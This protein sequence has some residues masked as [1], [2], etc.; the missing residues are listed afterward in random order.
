[1][2]GGTRADDTPVHQALREALV[3]CLANA[4]YYGRQGLVIVKKWNVITESNPV[5]FR[6][7]I[8]AA[9]SDGISDPHRYRQKCW[10]RQPHHLPRLA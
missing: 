3:N 8:D 1:M 10:R 9:K 6:I 4:D 2:D 7:E 5:S